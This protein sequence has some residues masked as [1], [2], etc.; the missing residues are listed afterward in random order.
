MSDA[1][2]TQLGRIVHGRIDEEIDPVGLD[3]ADER[4]LSVID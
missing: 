1:E 3:G 4:R 2:P